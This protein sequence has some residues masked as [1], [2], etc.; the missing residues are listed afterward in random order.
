M[1]Q[2]PRRRRRPALACLDCRRRKIKCDRNDPCAH[3][4][5]TKTQ[6]T[7]MVLRNENEASNQQRGSSLGSTPAPSAPR[8][9]SPNILISKDIH[10]PTRTQNTNSEIPD[11]LQRVQNGR[12]S[13]ASSSVHELSENVGDVLTPPFGLQNSQIIL[14][15]TRMLRWSHFV[16]TANEVKPQIRVHPVI[17]H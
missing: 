16:G 2:L 10:P 1:E 14:N 4:V 8:D 12:R 13:S 15:K 6:C 11:V 9:D 5:S 7:Y 3:C 17:L